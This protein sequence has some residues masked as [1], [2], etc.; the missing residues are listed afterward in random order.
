MLGIDD[1]NEKKNDN[2]DNNYTENSKTL[3]T[4]AVL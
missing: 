4:N 2:Y 1:Y 3:S